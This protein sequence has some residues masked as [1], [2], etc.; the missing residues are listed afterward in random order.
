M[1]GEKDSTP[2]NKQ[3]FTFI[4]TADLHLDSPFLGISNVDSE[5][6]E[7]LAK[8][9]F[10]TYDSI[11]DQCIERKVDFL[12]IAGDI[13]D[14]ADKSLYA[15]IKFLDGLRRLSDFGIS[16]YICHGNHDPLNGWS[17]RLK[18]PNNVHVMRGDSVECIDFKK[19]N[20]IVA[21]ISGI[22]YPIPHVENNL[23]KKFPVRM[24]E[25]P[26]TIGLLHCTVGSRDGHYPYSPCT[27]E[28][29]KYLNYDYWA[30]GHIHTPSQIST[31]DPIIVYSGT[32]QG[33]HPGECGVHGCFY[34]SV[35]SK[36]RVS[37]EFI[38][39]D[40]IRWYVQEISIDEI[41][42]EGELLE[43]MQDTIDEIHEKA[44]GRSVICRLVLTGRSPLHAFLKED[45]ILNNFIQKLR[46]T[47]FSNSS[48]I[49][50]DRIEDCTRLPVD[51]ETLLRRK[52]FVGDVANIVE[53]LYE[54]DNTYKELRRT[55]DTLLK[56][57]IGKN[58]LN[59]IDKE[60]LPDL[61]QRAENILLDYLLTEE[62]HAD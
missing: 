43:C 60:E 26:F 58:L 41:N 55:F 51:R 13:Y 37:F 8:S 54:N 3:Q 23:A 35:D 40:S 4:H 25:W 47:E 21:R 24:A 9:T 20:E 27:V 28:D 44:D 16:V 29:L 17:A 38:E 7:R 46:D 31:S 1:I 39:T 48:F 14:S 57:S 30:L 50:V 19:E 45:D 52:D 2:G 61:I 34:V 12:L 59:N 32:P 36:E 22:S 42:T 53:S 62:K 56:S 5:L 18:W 49:W 11:I 6:G 10:Q 15:Q 33:R